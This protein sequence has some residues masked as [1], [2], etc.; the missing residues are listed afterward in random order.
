MCRTAA[1][2]IGDLLLRANLTKRR[3]K[4]LQQCTSVHGPCGRGASV[5]RVITVIGLA[6]QEASVEAVQELLSE[7]TAAAGSISE[8][9]DRRTWAAVAAV[10][11]HGRPEVASLRLATPGI[12]HRRRGFV[13]EQTIR[14]GQMA[15]Q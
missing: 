4:W 13:H 11:G 10:V 9:H 8:Q 12:E 7:G 1:S 2:A 6:L 3:R 5:K 15:A 14:R